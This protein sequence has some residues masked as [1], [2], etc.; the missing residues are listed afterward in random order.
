MNIA[1][2]TLPESAEEGKWVEYKDARFLIISSK[3]KA[4]TSYLNRKSRT[5]SK[6]KFDADPDLSLEM[7]KDAYANIIIKNWE[8][9]TTD[10][11]TPFPYSKANARKLMELPDFRDW[12]TIEAG[13]L[14][15]F[16]DDALEAD[17]EEIK[18]S[19]DLAAPVGGE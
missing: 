2:E 16:R 7:T 14:S 4:F 9:V 8:N 17:T 10:G 18:S 5:V 15:T 13:Q 3:A 6:H 12:L 19:A 11:T 1:L